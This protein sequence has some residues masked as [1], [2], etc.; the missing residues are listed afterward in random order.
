MGIFSNL[1]SFGQKKRASDRVVGIDV[2]SSSIKVVEVQDRSGVLTLTTYGELQLGPYGGKDIGEIVTLDPKKEQQ[3]LIDILRESAVKTRQAVLAIPLASSFITTISLAAEPDEDIS[4]RVR[5]EA[6]KYIPAQISEV[7]LDW[8]EIDTGVDAKEKRSRNVLVAAI[9]NEA[10]RRFN[11]LMEFADFGVQPTEIECFSAIRALFKEEETNQVIVDIG[12]AS[13]KLYIVKQGLLRRMHRVRAGG[14]IA[15]KRIATILGV[16][17]AEAETLKRDLKAAGESVGDIKRA[18][19]SCYERAFVEFRQAINDY[20]QTRGEKI[21][22]VYLCGGGAL[23]AGLDKQLKDA[24]ACEVRAAN[25]FQKVA[26]PAFM[27]DTMLE[28]GRS[29]AVSLGAALR[30]FE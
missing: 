1:F 11:T 8:A 18:H 15:T 16:S 17:F 22:A 28:L 14:N 29:F 5:V 10:M 7:T 12:A 19:Q 2:G 6:R 27:E 9:E 25:P 24:L 23:F 30:R 26:Y 4:P 21:D 20:E 13:S 3:A